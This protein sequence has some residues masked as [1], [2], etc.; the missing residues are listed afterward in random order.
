[1]NTQQRIR[2]KEVFITVIDVPVVE[3]SRHLDEACGGDAEVRAEVESLL[4]ADALPP[5][6][7]GAMGGLGA[8]DG[9]RMVGQRI[10]HYV[11]KSLIGEGGMGVVYLAE[12]DQPMRDVALKL[13]RTGLASTSALRR[14]RDESQRDG[15]RMLRDLVGL[16]CAGK[17]RR[18]EV[19]ER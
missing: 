18:L 1:M 16:R 4:A 10:G 3:R 11:V 14:F 2:A 7:T 9:D 13:M 12:Q 6:Q 15:L 19:R 17:R 8:R 5:L